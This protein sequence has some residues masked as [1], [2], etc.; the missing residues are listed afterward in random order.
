MKGIFSTMIIS[1][2]LFITSAC[3]NN[4]SYQVDKTGKGDIYNVSREDEDMTKAME[5]AKLTLKQFDSILLSNNDVYTDFVL[6]VRFSEKNEVEHI[7]ARNIKIAKGGYTGI[8]DNTPEYISSIKLGDTIFIKESD[9]SDWQYFYKKRVVG[10]YTTKAIRKHMS[11]EERKKFDS[12][13]DSAYV[14]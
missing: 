1:F 3:N 14:D 10:S 9:V 8:I 2:I 7:W 5:T 6:K 12:D 4:N 13:Y 11:E